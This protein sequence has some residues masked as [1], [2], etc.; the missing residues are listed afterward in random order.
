M[1]THTLIKQVNELS[2]STKTETDLDLQKALREERLQQAAPEML[3]CL[4]GLLERSKN[5]DPLSQPPWM[6]DVRAIVEKVEGV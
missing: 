4:K 2:A 3:A 1:K 5:F 6:S